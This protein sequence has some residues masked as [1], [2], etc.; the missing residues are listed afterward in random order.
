MAAVTVSRTEERL[1]AVKRVPAERAYEVE[2]EAE[3]LRQLDHPGVVRCVDLVE[4]DDGGRAL[5]TSFVSSDTW[6]TRPL[7]NP[8][9]RA[10]GVAALSAV[11]A[12]LHELGMTHRYIT[13]AHVLHGEDDRPVLCSLTRAGDAAAEN[14]RI[15]LAALAELAYDDGIDRSPIANKLSSMA[16]AMRAGQLSARDMAH[17]LDRLLAQ[18]ASRNESSR[19]GVWRETLVSALRWPTS[20]TQQQA[21]GRTAVKS[22]AAGL[23]LAA[24]I[25]SAASL[26]VRLLRSSDESDTAES[27]P[28]P[29]TPAT[30]AGDHTDTAS[31]RQTGNNETSTNDGN[32]ANS[33][34]ESDQ[35]QSTGNSAAGDRPPPRS[36]E[37]ASDSNSSYQ[38]DD[39]SYHS[40]SA[41]RNGSLRQTPDAGTP[42]G[43]TWDGETILEHKGRRYSV[44]IQGDI[45]L[46][47]D[48]NCDGTATPSIVRPSNGTVVFFE[49]WPPP[50]ETISRPVHSRINTPTDARLETHDGCDMLRVHTPTGSHLVGMEKTP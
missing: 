47:G 10:A 41:P 44:G 20:R 49:M 48:W 43:A 11:V 23:V 12:D 31:N 33:N 18:R 40:D 13:P 45:V 19:L 25:A 16:D 15:D 5:H 2:R 32:T 50:G 34:T 38:G 24:L 42:D 3:L 17:K 8:T 39:N 30:S 14:R 26:G 37:S 4:T 36:S 22:V 29:A 6:E 46:A 7:T 27:L 9:E 28:R 35:P 21:S 1:I